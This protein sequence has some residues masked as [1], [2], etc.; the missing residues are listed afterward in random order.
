[1]FLTERLDAP[2][3]ENLLYH[4][5][6]E[7]SPNL[8]KIFKQLKSLGAFCLS[9]MLQILADRVTIH[10]KLYHGR[11]KVSMCIFVVWLF[12]CSTI[13]TSRKLSCVEKS[14]ILQNYSQVRC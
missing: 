2:S 13:Y 6:Q 14:N 10:Q 8:F 1:M 5:Y 12:A 11:P 9:V 4:V 3:D 7:E